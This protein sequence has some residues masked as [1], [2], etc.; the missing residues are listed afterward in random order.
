MQVGIA[1]DF[2]RTDKSEE[3][4]KRNVE[5]LEAYRAKLVVFGK[6][7]KATGTQVRGTVMPIVHAAPTIATMAITEEMK[8]FDAF[9]KLAL[10]RHQHKQAGKCAAL[11]HD[12]D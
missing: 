3:A 9:N 4:M 5:R 6:G 10:L 2:R 12:A 8:S 11:R 7:Q 1:V